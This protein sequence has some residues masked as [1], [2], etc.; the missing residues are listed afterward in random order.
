MA[1]ARCYPRFR[2]LP[3][4]LP[5][6]NVA[7]VRFVC[8]DELDARHGQEIGTD[9]RCGET[10]IHFPDDGGTP[11]LMAFGTGFCT[12]QIERELDSLMT[13]L[14]DPRVKALIGE[15]VER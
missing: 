4:A 12:H 8:N 7:P 9:Y 5:N 3:A 6:T 15:A 2:D 11:T 13:L 10:L 1:L 14:G